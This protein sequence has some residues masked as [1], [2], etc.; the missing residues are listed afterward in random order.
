MN[1]HHSNPSSFQP[2]PKSLQ[3]K[4]TLVFVGGLM[5]T[6]TVAALKI[7]LLT[8]IPKK[9]LGNIRI[10]RDS[11]TKKSKGFGF[12]EISAPEHLEALVK[13]SNKT[14]QEM[15]EVEALTGLPQLLLMNGRK[16]DI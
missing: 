12:F 9:H 13:D 14:V 8:F 16:L 3:P 2:A 4:P 10:L 6:T 1:H 7:H 15:L 11:R 5:H